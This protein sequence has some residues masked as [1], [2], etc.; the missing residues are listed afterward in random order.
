MNKYRYDTV[1]L[2]FKVNRKC[3]IENKLCNLLMKSDLNLQIKM[4]E[5]E[6]CE[7]SIYQLIL[8]FYP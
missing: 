7:Y 1:H 4:F 3:Y 6:F 2:K 5:F 8:P